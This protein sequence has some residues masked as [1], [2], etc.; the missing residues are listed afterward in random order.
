MSTRHRVAAL[1]LVALGAAG[2]HPSAELRQNTRQTA[3]RVL[4]AAM[5]SE[6]R[7]IKVHAAEALL[8][9][10]E[11]QDV[12]RTFEIELA[13]RGGEPQYRIGIWR[14]LAQ[15]AQTDQQR[16][17]WITK[18]V[19]AF[20]DPRSPDRLHAAETQATRWRRI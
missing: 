13:A 11:S 10:G 16:E 6:Q 15:A 1:V 20:R 14:V 5:E 2:A 12:A 4:R 17:P 8:S 3:L 18:I 19:A 9:L 7:W